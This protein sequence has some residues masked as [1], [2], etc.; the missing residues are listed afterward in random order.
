MIVGLNICISRYFQ[1]IL[2]T[3][4]K[5]TLDKEMMSKSRSDHRRRNKKIA[6]SHDDSD[7]DSMSHLSIT[8][9]RSLPSAATAMEARLLSWKR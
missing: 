7:R 4:S 9:L 5:T 8:E 6:A 1:D 2:F 3:G